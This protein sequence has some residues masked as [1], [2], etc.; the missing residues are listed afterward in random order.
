M[1]RLA[2]QAL[3]TSSAGAAIISAA[4]VT[5][6]GFGTLAGNFGARRTAS[7]GAAARPRRSAKRTKPR[8]TDRP[9]ATEPRS[10]LAARDASQ[11]RKSAGL[12][13]ASVAS[14]GISPRCW[15]RKSRKPARSRP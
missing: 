7:A 6:S 11:A 9:R 13:A 14:A 8:T 3:A 2:C 12:N 4:S 10:T 15:V 5:D 1:S